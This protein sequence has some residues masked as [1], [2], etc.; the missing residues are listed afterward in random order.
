[1]LAPSVGLVDSVGQAVEALGAVE[2]AELWLVE[3]LAAAVVVVAVAVA[4]E[5]GCAAA[6]DACVAPHA[7]FCLAP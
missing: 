6:P 7:P 1:M 4:R 2:D 5:L 3:A